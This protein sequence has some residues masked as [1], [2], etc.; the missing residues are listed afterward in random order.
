M[1]SY[2]QWGSGAYFDPQWGTY[3]DVNGDCY[4]SY[5]DAGDVI[6]RVNNK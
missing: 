5:D 3:L 6:D 2:A 4:V 1:Y